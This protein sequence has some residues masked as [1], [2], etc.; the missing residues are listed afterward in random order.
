MKPCQKATAAEKKV[1]DLN[2]GGALAL[3][4]EQNIFV[5]LEVGVGWESGWHAHCS[6]LLQALYC[7]ALH[8]TV[9]H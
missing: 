9:M 1:L 8:F 5:K 2:K 7:D 6:P 4:G 3:N